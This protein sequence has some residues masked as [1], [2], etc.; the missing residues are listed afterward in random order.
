MI[1]ANNAKD[2]YGA[3]LVVGVMSHIA[4]Q[5]VL[6]IAVVTNTIPNTG[7]SLPF[8]SYGG[9]SV[10]FLLIEVGLVINVARSIKI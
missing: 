5:V 7:I 9:T 6:N 1:V 3:L 10:M 8:I 2:L 4:I